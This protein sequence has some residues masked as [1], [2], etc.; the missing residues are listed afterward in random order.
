MVNVQAFALIICVPNKMLRHVKTMA[1][2]SFLRLDLCMV[3]NKES[4]GTKF[5][6][7]KEGLATAFLVK[8]FEVQ[9]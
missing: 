4:N 7:F 8:S 2:T 6:T 9:F 1:T 3:T 5:I